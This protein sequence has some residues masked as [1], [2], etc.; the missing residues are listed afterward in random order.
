MRLKLLMIK[1]S[2]KKYS[3]LYRIASPQLCWLT[4][5]FLGLYFEN[6][7]AQ[8]Q[9]EVH[10]QCN[11]QTCLAGDTLWW[12]G[13]V[14]EGNQFSKSSTNLYVELFTDSG[15]MIGHYLFPVIKGQTIGQ[16]VLPDS[17]ASG[18]Y[19]LRY[20]TK[21]GAASG[22]PCLTEIPISVFHE[23][24]KDIVMMKQKTRAKPVIDTALVVLNADTLDTGENG[25]N[26]WRIR[27]KDTS[28]Y[29]YSI[30]VTDLDCLPLGNKFFGPSET[31]TR[32]PGA[33]G[34]ST[35]TA[36]LQYAGTVSR[37][38]GRKIG[39]KQDL[40]VM[41]VKDST[42]LL[43]RVIPIGTNGR[44]MLGGLFFFG[45]ADLL[46]QLNT[47]AP[48]AKNIRIDLDP[49][50]SAPFHIPNGW[51]KTDSSLTNRKSHAVTAD[52]LPTIQSKGRQLKEVEIKGW[53]S[54][55]RELDHTYT[56]GEFSEPA[57]YAF[58]LRSETHYDLGAYLRSHLP[59][60]TGGYS[61]IDTPRYLGDPKRLLF[62]VDEQLRTW[63]ELENDLADVAYI[64]AFE[65][66]FIGDDPFTKWKTGVGGF[67]FK[68]GGAFKIP[69][70][71][72]PMVIAIYSRKGK[73]VKQIPGLNF[74]AIMGYN[75]IFRYNQADNRPPVVL[76]SP[77]Q[78]SNNTRIRFNNHTAIKHFR[79]T[80]TGFNDEG[81]EIE[82]T[83]VLPKE[84]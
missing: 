55:R 82:Y 65:N 80:L 35:D 58:D 40:L 7:N 29:H 59:G 46:Y 61:S 32:S 10:I 62:Y 73:D 33:S 9:E 68:G 84:N 20:F 42:V 79:I 45:K 16:V 66:S 78:D 52:Q 60:F 6:A 25:Y 67:A 71:S 31:N 53:K 11:Q 41:L 1:S 24:D 37:E 18:V 30:S 81:R 56:S 38:N 39:A 27:I 15:R 70:Q 72:T 74:I 76:W 57:M 47:T 34:Y 26:S 77:L 13:Y 8:A 2:Q 19:W 44:F 75:P 14:I 54:P 5:I 83:T 17:L 22:P 28:V 49:Y 23:R 4:A 12:K 3:G 64:K 43:N 50:S 63:D 48:D 36:Y 21:F 51:V 69:V